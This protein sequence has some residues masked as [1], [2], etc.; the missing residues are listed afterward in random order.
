[1]S[2]GGAPGQTLSCGVVVA[3]RDDEGWMTLLLRAYHHW[4]FPK[5]IVEDG[6][7]PM[8]AAQRELC[9]ETGID[10]TEF[11]WGDRFMEEIKLLL[12]RDEPDYAT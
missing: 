12:D 3:R 4:D 7:D 6:E 2:D 9:E 1:M 5:G 10:E 11:E 8:Q